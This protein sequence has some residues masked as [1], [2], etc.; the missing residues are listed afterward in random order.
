MGASG[1]SADCGACCFP[2]ALLTGGGSIGEADAPGSRF[3]GSIFRCK[4]RWRIV[5]AFAGG[6]FGAGGD[7]RG[8]PANVLRVPR[9]AVEWRDGGAWVR[10]LLADGREEPRP[11]EAGLA[12]ATHVEVR[13]GLEEGMRVLAP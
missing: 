8:C 5:L 7:S 10:V 13:A 9:E 6:D 12:D 4:S 2:E 1:P 3:G 11:I